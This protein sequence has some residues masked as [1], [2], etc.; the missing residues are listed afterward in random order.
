MRPLFIFSLLF[1]VLTGQLDT[2]IQNIENMPLRTKL[3][4]GDKGFFRQLN[5]GPEN[6]RDEIKLR[7]RMLQ[8]HQKLALASLGLVAYQSYLG[9]Q[10][11]NGDYSKQQEHRT[12]SKITWGAYMTSASLSYFAPPAQK[13]DKRISSIKVHQWLSYVHF[14][15][16]MALPF[17]GKNIVTSNDYDAA[18]KAHQN[19]ATLTITSMSL[20]ALLTFLPY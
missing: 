17:L 20:S 18:L 2:T 19:I 5:F 13:Y 3:L 8:N 7:V 1:N 16:M 9:N 14:A 6:R 15:G 4:W 12:F 11:V 10:M